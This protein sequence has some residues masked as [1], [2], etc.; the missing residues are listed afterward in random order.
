MRNN[1]RLFAIMA[2]VAIMIML[3]ACGGGN[4]ANNG[5]TN[6][7]GGN[8]GAPAGGTKDI[9]IKAENWKFNP[10]EIK[11]NVGDTIN[12]K[13]ENVSGNH[14]IEIP[15][16]NVNLK[17]GETKSF[18]VDKAGSYAFHCSIQCGSGHND[19]VGTLV[20]S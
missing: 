3:T 17:S 11:V 19:M 18:T 10:K 1:Y 15:D 5:G 13:M 7:G 20:V 14:G 6:N 8:A 16:L 9:T 4:K 12:L 2:A